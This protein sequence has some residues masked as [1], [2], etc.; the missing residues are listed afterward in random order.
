MDEVTGIGLGDVVQFTDEELRDTL[1]CG[2]VYYPAERGDV[3]HVIGCTPDPQWFDLFFERTGSRQTCHIS[4]FK[5][6]GGMETGK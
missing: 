4:E 5:R 1:P 3:A 6:L 2:K